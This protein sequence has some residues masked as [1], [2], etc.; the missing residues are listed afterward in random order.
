MVLQNN[1]SKKGFPS[2]VVYCIITFKLFIFKGSHDESKYLC[3]ICK[4]KETEQLLINNEL[5]SHIF[6]KL[7][8]L[9]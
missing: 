8:V 7:S 1:F 4:L 9:Y 5:S 6:C 2:T 3:A